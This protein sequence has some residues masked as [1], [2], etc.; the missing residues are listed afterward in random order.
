MAMTKMATAMA[1]MAKEMMAIAK[2]PK[3]SRRHQI[4]AMA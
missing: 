4:L 3:Q 1:K 2:I